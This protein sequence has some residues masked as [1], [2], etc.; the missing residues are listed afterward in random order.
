MGLTRVRAEQISDIDYKQAVRVISTTNISDLTSAAPSVVDGVAISLNDRILVN[1][2]TTQSQNGLYYAAV[3][4]T[5]SNG[6][7]VRTQ[8]GNATGEI[9]AGMIVMVTEGAMYADTLWKLITNN[10]IVIGVT[11]LEFVLNSQ[12]SFDVINANGTPVSANTTSSTI[13]YASGNNLVITGSDMTDTVTF[14]VSDTPSFVGNVTAAGNLFVSRDVSITGN[15]TIGANLNV[16]NV[17]EYVGATGN[18]SFL[19]NLLPGSSNTQ[20]YSLGLP[21]QP[22]SNIFVANLNV[23]NFTG[24]D[25]SIT[26]TQTSNTLIVNNDATINGN[27]TVL[28]TT[29]TI[30]SNIIVT[31]DKNIELANNIANLVNLDGA[32]LQVGNA[33]N[34]YVTNWTYNYAANAWS[35]NVGVTA[36]GNIT[37]SNLFSPGVV[38]AAGNVRGGNINTEGNVTAAGN[39][40]GSYILGNGAFLTG[41]SASYGNA[42]VADYLP[43][44]TGNITAGNISTT[45]NITANY[46][47]GNGVQL[48]GIATTTDLSNTNSNVSNVVLD[49]ANT[50]SNVSNVSSN[51]SN[52]STSLSNTN[53][54]V[55][56]LTTSLGNTNSN[57]SNLSNALAN[58]NSNVTTLS[59]TVANNSA[60]ITTL[61][62]Q[63]YANANVAAYLPTYTGN[64]TAGNISTTGNIAGNYFI[65]NG[66][67]LTGL[68]GSYANTDA[69]AYFA[70][71]TSNANISITGNVL[72]TADISATGNITGN[73][74]IGNGSQLTG[75]AATLSGNLAGNIAANGFF[76]NNLTALSVSGQISG[77]SIYPGIF[78]NAIAVG[79]GAGYNATKQNQGAISVGF[80]AGAGGQGNGA[81]AVGYYAAGNDLATT[82]QGSFAIAVG[83]FAAFNAQSTNAIAIGHQAGYSAQG[84]SSIAIGV[85]AAPNAQ[86]NNTIVINATGSAWATDPAS[87]NALYVAPIRSANNFGVLSY[88]PTTKEV[89]YSDVVSVTGNIATSGNGRLVGNGFF[90]TNLNGNN[91]SILAFGNGAGQGSQGNN[92]IAM[93]VLAGQFNQGSNAVAIGSSAALSAQGFN[94]IAIGNIAGRFSLTNSSIAIGYAAAIGNA[95]ANAAQN[96]G[97]NIIALNATGANLFTPTSNAFYVNPVRNDTVTAI[98]NVAVYNATSKEIA[99][100]NTINLG[101]NITGGNIL[102]AGLISATGNV[103]VG[104][105][106]ISGNIVDSGALN[107]I[108]SGNG[109]ITLSANGTGIVAIAGIT[110][111]TGNILTAGNITGNV[112]IG[113]GSQLTGTISNSIFYGSNIGIGSLAGQ[114]SQGSNTTAVGYFAGQSSQGLQA[115]A[116][117]YN[118][119]QSSQG[120][121]SVAVGAQAGQSSQGAQS[122]AV[123]LSA[124]K[125]NQGSTAV[126]IG[127]QA[128]QSAQGGN[129][130][131]IGYLAG[132]NYQGE[133][134][135]AVGAY[136]GG[137]GLTNPN[138]GLFA[139]AIGFQ[140]A[141]AQQANRAIAIGFQAGSSAQGLNSIA[142]GG[143]AAQSNQPANSIVLN[144]TGQ[145]F[146]P[147][148]ASAFYVQPVRNDTVTA[149]GNV[150]VYNASTKELAYSNTISLGGSITSVDLSVTG[151]VNISN[152]TVNSYTFVPQTWFKGTRAT[153]QNVTTLTDTTIIW[154][155]NN[156]PLSWG[157]TTTGRITPTKAGWYEVTSRV[158]F[159]AVAGNSSAQ[160]NHQILVNGTQAGFSQAPNSTNTGAGITMIATAMVSLNGTSD[161]ITT[162]AYSTLAAN[163]QQIVG[164]TSSMV[165]VKWV[166]ST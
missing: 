18:I 61:Q 68:S 119:G 46:F 93:G 13:N 38:S 91:F 24:T 47:I 134:A 9:N 128:G 14:A 127:Y 141:L 62:G 43:T 8:D 131:A 138:I 10:P 23:A 19:G 75:I 152:V 30:N 98:G 48:T 76:I 162:T 37:G 155:S 122:V 118:A 125:V 110:S 116:V 88:S 80:V 27:L 33:V 140:A 90:V 22:W 112:F 117:G 55:S 115:V 87:A 44:Y 96:T 7:W 123:G 124:G 69:Q 114:V 85:C 126:A 34:T 129:G 145:S 92:A 12:A 136:A 135:V 109:N 154:N 102:T 57:V 103:S 89:T 82:S 143:F 59:N 130:V 41:L 106:N 144:A 72:T 16:V 49:I 153:S 50:N 150:A 21:G 45:G 25:L 73:V 1:G 78:G 2:Q 133:G 121:S 17:N 4:G 160:I 54:N 111:A 86:P 100:S 132:F 60:N 142:I 97:N 29:T 66:S 139:V 63:V 101:G 83:A 81:V 148:T 32:G 35:T 151:T 104:N 71:G 107:I 159:S 51:V 15:L 137:V 36:V 40:T 77:N 56:N 164:N 105:L 20:A 108:T 65:G 149:I 158:L 42:N 11:G 113:N 58:T 84:N 156:D 165:L 67:Q 166:S 147:A 120:V 5:G 39:I 53:S 146:N 94:A 79:D 6:S 70:S 64:I 52:L 161:Y 26:G 157:N 31:N 95:S 163:V 28:G 74:F 3:V 99:Y